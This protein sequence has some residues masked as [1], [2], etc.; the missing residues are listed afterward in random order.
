MSTL[1]SRFWLFP[2]LVAPFALL[3]LACDE[4]KTPN[5]TGSAG[6]SGTAGTSGSAGAPGTGG[7]LGGAG[8]GGAAGRGG[9]G[10]GG[11][12][13]AAFIDTDVV[14]ARFTPAGMLDTTFGT[15][16]VARVDLGP[17]AM[18]G[19]ASVRDAPWGIAR[20][21]QN[22][23][24]V[25]AARKNIG[26]RTDSDRV[27]A[28]LSPTG[29]LD[30]TFGDLVPNQTVV[31][32]GIHTLDIGNLSDNVRHGFVQDDGKI[33][34]SGY[35]AQPTGV[36]TQT[37]NRIVVARLHGGDAASTGGAGG[38]GT[39]GA[40]GATASPAPGTYD[41][42]FGVMGVSTANPFSSTDPLMQWG[43]AEAYG[44][45][46][47]ST[48]AYVT[49]GYGRNAATGTVNVLSFRFSPI[50]AFDTTYAVNGVFE[51]DLTSDNDRARN[52]T[53]LPGDRVLIVGSATPTANN[54]DGMLMIL[55]PGGALD[56]TFNTTGY[57]TYKFDTT[58]DRPDEALYGVAVSP[59]GMFAAAVGY[60]NAGSVATNN[61]D[62]VL[63]ILPLGGTGTEFAQAVP[64]STTAADRFWGVTFDADNKIVATGYVTESGDRWLAVAR[65]STNGTPDTTFGSNG[66]AKVNASASTATEQFE[67][68]RGVVVQSDGKIVIGGAAEH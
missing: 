11:T 46:R 22:R 62:A 53:V 28:R 42:S 59:N 55:T 58:D 20:D 5:Q 23:L 16:G 44:I 13:G 56:A 18:V 65:F 63:V 21:A 49:A 33:V 60:R 47:Q 24:H 7:S 48:G 27:V 3:L 52:I 1:A 61:D 31:R 19:T 41:T 34:T 30:T 32:T 45:A 12:G 2:V 35:Y 15:S 14:L 8:G 26:G 50:G 57:K 29:T 36:G 4:D 6:T 25:F 10:G 67:E 54:V 64:L 39:G 38:T 68:A 51:K 43:T 40:S 66:V 17:G 9:G 37:A